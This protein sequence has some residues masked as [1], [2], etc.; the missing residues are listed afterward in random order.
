MSRPASRQEL[1]DRIRQSSRLEVELEEMIRLGFWK[2]GA[3]YKASADIIKRKG[4]IRKELKQLIKDQQFFGSREEALKEIHRIRK[5]ESRKRRAELKLKR[6]AEK[7]KRAEAWQKRKAKEVLYL[8][9]D[10]S[11]SLGKI[12]NNKEKLEKYGLPD[13][14]DHAAL[15]DFLSIDLVELKFLSYARKVSKVNHYKRFQMPKKTGGFRQISAPQP[16]LKNVQ[17]KVY[18]QLLMPISVDDNA[19]GFLA[20]R[21]IVSNA[22]PHVGADVVMNLDLKNF[23]PTLTL[24][25]VIGV[26]RELG[27][28]SGVATVLA[29]ICT[30]QPTQEVS[31]DGENWH[32]AEGDRCLPQGAPTSPMI[33]NIICRRMDVRLTGIAKKHGFIYTRYADDMTFSAKGES[34]SNRTKLLWHVKKVVHEEGFIIHPD[35]L[36]IMHKGSHQEVTGVVV[37]DKLSI[38]RKKVRKYRALLHHLDVK[39]LEGARWDGKSERLLARAL[40]YGRYLVMIDR[41]RFTPMLRK[42]ESL[43]ERFGFKQEIRF[44]TQVKET[45]KIVNEQEV[46]QNAEKAEV[47]EEDSPLRSGFLK[48]M[49]KSIFGK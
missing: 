38:C 47:R 22:T 29:L 40:G 32:I 49:M 36:R 10:V 11:R 15:A 41:D 2:E 26:F 8:G 16:R 3:A 5:E 33:T 20:E 13:L 37:N 4:E 39:G 27:Y 6:E 18:T 42:M 45:Q 48:K 21:S 23:F 28:S 34:C 17:W 19:H 12:E 30:E 25:R 1:Y 31:I 9:E 35:K 7:K 14:V 44:P 43:V 24:K 46:E